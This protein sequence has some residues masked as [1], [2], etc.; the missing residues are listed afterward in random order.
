MLYSI[1]KQH[2]A[3]PIKDIFFIFIINRFE[4][5]YGYFSMKFILFVIWKWM[6]GKFDMLQ[7]NQK[8]GSLHTYCCFE[9]TN[10][11]YLIFIHLRYIQTSSSPKGCIREWIIF[12]IVI[13]VLHFT[14][15]PISLSLRALSQLHRGMVE[16]K[17]HPIKTFFY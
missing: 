17:I 1:D 10:I 8:Y 5:I 9:Q 4:S 11:I 7:G 15:L 6:F 12:A 14:T 3:I 13:I 2:V 16:D